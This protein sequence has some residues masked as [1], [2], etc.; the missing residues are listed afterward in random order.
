V[1]VGSCDMSRR[2]DMI[3]CKAGSATSSS[4]SAMMLARSSSWAYCWCKNLSSF[5]GGGGGV[6]DGVLALPFCL[7][8]GCCID[9]GCFSFRSSSCVFSLRP[10]S[11]VFSAESWS[12]I[13]F[14]LV[15]VDELV[16]G[17]VDRLSSEGIP[18]SIKTFCSFS[19]SMVSCYL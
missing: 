18:R 17:V 7:L 8:T 19:E 2:G 4:I 1:R 16:G 15:V 10:S 14:V 11:C 5:G 3:F 9:S 12:V 6:G 13:V